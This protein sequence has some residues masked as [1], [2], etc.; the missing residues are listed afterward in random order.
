MFRV[1]YLD[2]EGWINTDYDAHSLAMLAAY[3]LGNKYLTTEVWDMDT[4]CL[5]WAAID[6]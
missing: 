1:R 3:E 2:Q 4:G 5:L 6:N